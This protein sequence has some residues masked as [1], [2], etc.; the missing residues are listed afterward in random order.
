MTFS[1][2]EMVLMAQGNNNK[3]YFYMTTDSAATVDTSGY[4]D[5]FAKQ[6]DVGDVIKVIT[7][8][9]VED[10]ETVSGVSEHV[11]TSNDGTTV[12]VSDTLLASS[13]TDSD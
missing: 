3:L 11:V 6:L 2:S 5:S 12:N 9:N 4:F 13:F 8:N 7:V 10:A 1:A